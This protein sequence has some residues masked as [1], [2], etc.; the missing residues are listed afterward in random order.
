MAHTS[1]GRRCREFPKSLASST[2][3]PDESLKWTNDDGVMLLKWRD[4]RDVFM[5]ATN[6]A[7]LDE[8]GECDGTT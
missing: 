7:G 2:L 6:E 1:V 3:Q 8:V 5:V 4:K